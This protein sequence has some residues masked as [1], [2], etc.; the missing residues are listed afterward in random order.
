MTGV[1]L[2]HILWW[3]P[4]LD[5]GIEFI[6][7][8]SGVRPVVGGVHPGQGTRNALAALDG[9]CYFEVLSR[10]PGQ[11][12]A[13]GLLDLDIDRQEQ[14]G[15]FAFC[16]RSTDLDRVAD[17]AAALGLV[18]QGP[19]PSQRMTP[20]GDVLRWRMLLLDGNP[21]TPSLP[22]FIDWMDTPHPSTT[23]PTG[24]GLVDFWVTH[25][26]P[27]ELIPIYEVLG[28][29]VRIEPGPVGLEAEFEGPTGRFTL[30]RW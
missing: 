12:G 18:S 4:D 13:P 3:S 30:S 26:E 19:T 28:V 24:L 10:D 23:T 1:E 22:F 15:L 29:P 25:P 5:A 16:C 21:D 17:R 27:E 14:S 2:D 20:T 7:A 11:H 6:D 8:A 9:G